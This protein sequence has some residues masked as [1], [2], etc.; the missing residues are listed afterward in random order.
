MLQGC[1]LQGINKW[2]EWEFMCGT[3]R[4]KQSAVVQFS[5]VSEREFGI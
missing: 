3:Q 4:T 2:T 1:Y 5:D